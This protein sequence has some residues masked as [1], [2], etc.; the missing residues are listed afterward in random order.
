M[1][2]IRRASIED[3]Q[4]AMAFVQ[5]Q[6]TYVETA[7]NAAVYTDIQYPSLVPVDT[8]ANPFAQSVTYYS[9]DQFGRAKWINGNSDDIPLAGTELTATRTNVYTAAIGYG[10]G[11]EEVNVAMLLGYPLQ[12]E[13][14]SAA[15]RAY[16][17]M[18]ERIAIQGDAEK[19]F[20]GLINYPTVPIQAAPTG[21]WPVATGDLIAADINAILLGVATATAYT[22]ISN[23]LLLPV[24][25][26]ALIGTKMMNTTT[27]SDTVLSHV[28]RTNVYTLTTGQPLLIR[29]ALGL[30]TAG[31]TGT[32][33]RMVAYRRAPEVLKLHVPMPHRF[34]PVYQDGPL[35]WKV[36]GVFRTGGLDIRR[37]LEVRYM[38]NI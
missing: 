7:V 10:Y 27:N 3:A 29:G 37:P 13:D 14:A 19:N 5:S 20:K 33:H 21:N 18:M 4:A 16:E 25:R 30:D 28:L 17:E 31:A 34:L 6:L 24:D 23:T 35:N 32:L 36:P 11:W 15:R 38:D 26:Y 22:S 9:S 8:S 12:T 1:Q 2:T